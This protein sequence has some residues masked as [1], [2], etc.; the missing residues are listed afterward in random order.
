M[1]LQELIFTVQDELHRASE[2]HSCIMA[3]AVMLDVLRA[4]GIES[5]YALT[6]KP[7]VLNPKFAERLNQEPFPQT[8]EQSAQWEADGCYMVAIGHG[9]GSPNEWPAHLVVVIPNALK[10]RDA[11]CDL[12]ITQASVPRWNIQLAPI[13]V[14]VRES[15]LDGSE[16]FA[17][18]INGCRVIY[19]AFPE[20]DSF[21]RTPIW[22]KRL[23]REAIAKRV[24]RR[25]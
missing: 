20:D 15:F 11:V 24:L 4:K 14:G 10:G 12:T 25:L 23:K 1:D 18:T 6:V 9:E 19:R 7:R 13:L 5:A 16:G 8:T 3:A 17:L 22:T 2:E 21:K